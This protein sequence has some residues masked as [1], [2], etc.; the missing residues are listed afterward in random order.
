[1]D[2]SSDA[3]HYWFDSA[4]G[5]HIGPEDLLFTLEQL[6][7]IDAGDAASALNQAAQ[8]IAAALVAEKVDIFLAR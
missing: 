1:M 6:I 8:L 3:D 5:G 2:T 7:A 4:P